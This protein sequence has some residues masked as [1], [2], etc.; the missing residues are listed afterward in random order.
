[1]FFAKNVACHPLKKISTWRKISMAVW[2]K[3]GDPSVYGF[4]EID[5]SKMV[6]FIER[7]R[8]ES[9]EKITVTHAAIKAL[10]KMLEKFPE[11]N[12]VIRRS[13]LYVRDHIDIF[14]QVFW[15]E[16]TRADLSGAKIRNAHRMSIAEVARALK[17]QSEKIRKGDD[18]HLKQTKSM[19]R[20]MTPRLLKWSIKILGYIGYELNIRPAFLNLPPDPFGAV[21][22]TNI[23]IF[24]IKTGW[25]PLVPFS[26]TPTVVAMGEITPQPVVE[27]GQVVAKPMLTLGVTSDHRIVDGY[28]GGLAAKYLKELLE[29]PSK[30][31]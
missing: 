13:R 29:E 27:N 4:L 24:G 19:L 3:P 10:A 7:L 22:L 5:A 6:L 21:M 26:R 1:M 12:V 18:P 14:V 15:E 11:L 9:G 31:L 8:Q 2:E 23:G 28:L 16:K 25:A 30:L 20:F 17:D